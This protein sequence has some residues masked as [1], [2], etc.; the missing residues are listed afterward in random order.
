MRRAALLVVVASLVSGCIFPR[1]VDLKRPPLE[2]HFVLTAD[3]VR[4]ET[5]SRGYTW[6]DVLRAGVYRLE[7]EDH[8]GYYYR[9][10][11]A[12]VIRLFDKAAKE[13]LETGKATDPETGAPAPGY[14]GYLNGGL[15]L[16]KRPGWDPKLFFIAG[17]GANPDQVSAAARGSVPVQT[18]AQG[19]GAA[20]GGELVGAFASF[21][22][23]RAIPVSYDSEKDFVASIR[24]VVGPP[25]R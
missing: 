12:C 21:D 10:E 23:G 17:R 22:E 8:E 25:A 16:P 19:V 11:G 2:R 20:L 4:T 5:T 6:V 13:Y 7:A 9:G 18:G 24:I 1:W 14:A 15:W 3:H